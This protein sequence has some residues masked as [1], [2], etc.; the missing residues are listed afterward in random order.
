MTMKLKLTIVVAVLALLMPT[1]EVCARTNKVDIYDLSL[2]ENL[3]LPVIKNAKHAERVQQYQ[4]E[5][6]VAFKKKN[7]EVEMMRDNEVIIFTFPAAKLFAPND[8]TLTKDGA[9]ALQPLLTLLKPAG[10]Y[11]MLLVMHSDNTGSETYTLDLTRARVNAV[12]DWIDANASV[13]FVVPYALGDTDPM[14]DNNSI[15]NRAR[16]R[17]LEVYLVPDEVMLEQAKKG[18][19]TK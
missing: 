17:R 18:R 11:K 19:I 13:D 16:N 2:E 3:E 7:M 12:Y 10:F 15:E 6:A 5:A 8:T 9:K 14:V 4:Y 1:P